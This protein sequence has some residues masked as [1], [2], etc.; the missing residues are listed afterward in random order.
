MP[1]QV[2]KEMILSHMILSIPE[3]GFPDI[4][5]CRDSNFALGMGVLKHRRSLF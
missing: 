3:G 4:G 1:E 2:Q 5:S